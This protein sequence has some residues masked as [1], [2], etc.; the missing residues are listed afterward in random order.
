M[1][2]HHQQEDDAVQDF[3]RTLYEVEA[4]RT[5][6]ER[7]YV[8]HFRIFVKLWKGILSEKKELNSKLKELDSARKSL[9]DMSKKV[10]RAEARV[11]V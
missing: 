9:R 11:R 8:D 5:A 4:E 6:T 3:L 1:H 10:T 2:M 7:R